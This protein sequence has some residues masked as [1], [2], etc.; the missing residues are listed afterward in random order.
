MS[1]ASEKYFWFL[2]SLTTI[3]ISAQAGSDQ[4]SVVEQRASTGYSPLL[5]RH[6]NHDELFHVLEGKFRL[7]VGDDE[8]RLHADEMLLIPKGMPHTFIIESA[9]DGRWLDITVG[10]EYENFVRA[11]ARPAERLDIPPA[12]EDRSPENL[13]TNTMTA[14]QFGIDILGPGLE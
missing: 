11:L 14:A 6:R 4:L 10:T 5:H 8:L 1:T 7:K 3:R 9:E 13:L 2:G 12:G